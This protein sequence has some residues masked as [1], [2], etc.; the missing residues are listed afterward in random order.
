MVIVSDYTLLS[1]EN[2][3]IF[4]ESIENPPCPVCQSPLEHRDRKPRISKQDGGE[5]QWLMIERRKCT[6]QGCRRL[7]SVLPD[8]LVPYKHYVSDLIADVVD[9]VIVPED[10]MNEELPCD[11]TMR[12]WMHWF[13]ANQ[14][15]IE[16][17]CRS[18]TS[19]F[20]NGGEKAF[21]PSVSPFENIRNTEGRWLAVVLRMV[22]NSGGFLMPA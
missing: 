8:K 12:R 15:R 19:R 10:P 14:L 17:Y 11:T 5:T 3:E 22:Y 13:M 9:E 20:L 16:G 18:V 7:H 2:G 21:D 1:K 4:V 6:N